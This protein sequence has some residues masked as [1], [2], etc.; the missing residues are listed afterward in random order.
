MA[1]VKPQ[2]FSL[3][4]WQ[5]YTTIR[6]HQGPFV[7]VQKAPD[8]IQLKSQHSLVFSSRQIHHHSF[9]FPKAVPGSH[10]HSPATGTVSLSLRQFPSLCQ[11]CPKSFTLS[12]TSVN[13]N[14]NSC[15]RKGRNLESLLSIESPLIPPSSLNQVILNHFRKISNLRIY[16]HGHH[17]LIFA[18][19]Q[20]IHA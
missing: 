1:A 12:Y 19:F 11:N 7:C 20:M 15:L 14:Y 6:I 16:M 9:Q 18:S 13:K 3:V 5:T 4:E 17:I 2:L 10:Y 8:R